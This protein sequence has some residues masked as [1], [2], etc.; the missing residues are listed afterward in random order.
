MSTKTIDSF[1]GKYQFLSN[2]S[3]LND[4]YQARLNDD[5]EVLGA[6]TAAVT[7]YPTVEHAYH[8]SKTIIR[9]ERLRIANALEP[10]DAKREAGLVT[11]RSDWDA[12]KLEIMEELIRAKFTSD[13]ELRQRLLQTGTA[14]IV[15]G[16]AWGDRYW[17]VCKGTGH[18]HLGKIIMRVRSELQG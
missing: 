5:E 7:R 13:P 12:R 2:F 6:E 18:N 16:N 14:K 17:G 4:E 1:R 3:A 11:L 15:E 9:E 10:R 8:A